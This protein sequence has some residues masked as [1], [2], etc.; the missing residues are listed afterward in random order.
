MKN[1]NR[2]NNA[3]QR[4]VRRKGQGF[5]NFRFGSKMN[6]KKQ[7]QEEQKEEVQVSKK[8]KKYKEGE[9]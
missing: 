7:E 8:G 6:G 3:D 9:G 2:K 1:R 5:K 4:T